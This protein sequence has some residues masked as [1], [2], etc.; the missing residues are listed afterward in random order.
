MQ[1][2][3]ALSLTVLD[4]LCSLF[5]CAGLTCAHARPSAGSLKAAARLFALFIKEIA[6]GGCLANV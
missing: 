5:H 6:F 1:A 4:L 3:S 2:Q